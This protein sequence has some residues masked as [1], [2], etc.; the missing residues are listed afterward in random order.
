MTLRDLPKFLLRRRLTEYK[1]ESEKTE[2]NAP[3]KEKKAEFNNELEK[4]Q[5]RISAIVAEF[6]KDPEA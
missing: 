4:V 2:K 3:L 5:K 6:E 1:I